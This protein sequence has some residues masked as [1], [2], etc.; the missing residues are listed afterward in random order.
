MLVLLALRPALVG[1]QAPSIH[2]LTAD[3]R[4]NGRDGI[5]RKGQKAVV[6]V[7]LYNTGPY[8]TRGQL[9]CTVATGD[10]VGLAQK[11]EP[12]ALPAG[13]T[14][15][16][17]IRYRP[18]RAGFYRAEFEWVVG[19]DTLR[20]F[21]WFGYRPESIQSPLTRPPDFRVYWQKAKADLAAIPPDF[22]VQPNPEY[23]TT[24]R[25]VYTVEM[26]SLDN[27]LIR[28]Y[29]VV[30]RSGGPF[31]AV[32]RLPGYYEH[33]VPKPEWE[34]FAV[35]YLNIRGHGNSRDDV[36]ADAPL[37]ARNIA[38]K[39]RYFYR[40]AYL[41]CLRA[42]D[43]L[44]SRP[45]VDTARVAVAG[46][47]QGGALSIATAALDKRI[48]YC[49]P[50]MPFLSDFRQYFRIASFPVNNL[51]EYQKRHPELT[52]AQMHATLDYV[53]VKNLAPWVHCPVLLSVGLRDTICPPAINLSAYNQ[54]HVPKELRVYPGSGHKV[55]PAQYAYKEAW[56][57]K[58]LGL[59]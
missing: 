37:I 10:R 4:V 34:G 52:W 51:A 36:P 15:T 55:P 7:H 40:G 46:G 6:T 9:R 27:A 18:R 25:V 17:T 44:C 12:V 50:D 8:V 29:Y 59:E 39:D 21:T 3:L 53:D 33:L 26:R 23:T 16:A 32:L 1:A 38:D 47:S 58:R 45:E 2:P 54:L 22:S 28:G 57:R 41:D 35:L 49:L 56:L 43:F 20:G 24:Q 31:P 5:L 13:G 11:T 30:P 14:V 48:K 42:V 19:H